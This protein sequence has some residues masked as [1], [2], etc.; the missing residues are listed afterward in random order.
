MLQYADN[1]SWTRGAH[2]LKFGGEL[3]RGGSWGL[4]AG[5]GITAIPR[6]LGGDLATS[7]ISATAISGTN[8]PGLAGSNAAGNNARMRNLLSF[9]AGSLG[10]IT[11]YYYMQDPNK[12]DSWDDYKTYAGKIRDLRANEFSLF[13]KDDWKIAKSLTL[14]LGL[15]YDYLGVPYEANGLMPLPS[16]GGAAAFG[17][18]GRSFDEWMQPG[19]RADR[20]VFQYVGKNS[21]HPDIPWHPDDWNNF[22]PAVGFAWQIPWFGAGKTT[23]R[24]GYQVTYQIGDGFSSIVQETN[25]PGT[26]Q[27]VTYTGDSSTNAYLDLAK[28]QSLIPVPVPTKPLQPISL[29]ER[30][31]SLYIPDPNLVT[32][33][34]QNLT[35]AITRSIRSNMSLDV[36]YIGILGRKQRSASNNINVPNF[37][38]NGLQAAF[39]AIRAGGE[40]DLL[41]RMFNGINVAGAGFGPVGTT[42]NGIPQTAGLHMRSST[43]FNSNLANGNYAALATTLN[44]LNYTGA[45]NPGLPPIP[46]GE[47]GAVMRYNQFPENFIVAN[48][49][50][51][52]V[53]LM[54]NNISNNYHSLNLQFGMRPIHGVSTETTYSWSKNLGSGL[55][56]ADGLGQVFTDPLN[57][58][59]D[60]AQL[61]DTRVHDFRSNGSFELPIGPNRLILANSSGVL[62]RIIEGWQTSWIVNMNTGQPLSIAAQNML[63][64]NGTPDIVG[65]FDTRSGEVQFTG[66]P[67]GS[68]FP[69][70]DFKLARDPQCATIA[71]TL[72]ASCTLNALTDAKTGQVLLQNPKPGTRGTLGQRVVEGPGRWRFDAAMGKSF[73]VTERKSLQFRMDVRN[74]LNH[75]EPNPAALIMNINDPNFGLLT[76]TNAK[77]ETSFRELQAS[78]RFNF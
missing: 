72:Q 57:R 23:L 55:P 15:R 65:A 42:L 2:A 3:R 11:Q 13:F 34:A 33:Y 36:R 45:S 58:R 54:T 46:A 76:G 66:G 67:T 7:P 49:Q 78:L 44:T 17:I 39:D 14:N 59:A 63:Y 56:G 50:F 24:G 64:S 71:A 20:T 53:N 75:P 31:Q 9:L 73:K 4:D 12:L 69:P 19:T 30:S 43:L 21:P 47:L 77:S 61:P 26:S 35:F 18:S 27:N 37:R 10:S 74:V 22:G 51:N 52:G 6:A 68:Y 32:P 1:V 40:S 16:G 62:A 29:S 60:Y 28:L 41:N 48:P 5:I 38:S 70:A 25:A 8:M